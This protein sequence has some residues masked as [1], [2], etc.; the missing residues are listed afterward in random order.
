[1]VGKGGPWLPAGAVLLAI[2]LLVVGT[3]RPSRPFAPLAVA[4]A[5]FAVA[6]L[7]SLPVR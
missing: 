6:W 1:V 7:A 2:A 5:L 4:T 3:R